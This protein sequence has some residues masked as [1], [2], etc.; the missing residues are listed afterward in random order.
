MKRIMFVCVFLSCFLMDSQ[1]INNM[2][3][4]FD[5]RGMQ[6]SILYNHSSI[7]DINDYPTQTHNI[8]NFYQA[9]KAISFSD[10]EQRLP[11]LSTLKTK[12]TQE[13]LSLEVPLA[14]LF[15][16][17]DT[18]N[19]VASNNNLIQTSDGNTFQ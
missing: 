3:P 12:A 18:F 13:L 1:N 16:E 15:T 8:Y 4:D 11:S 14:L 10:F 17:Y 9:Y 6:T 7:H 5:K 2:F 19:E